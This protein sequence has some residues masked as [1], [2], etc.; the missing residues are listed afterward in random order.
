LTPIINEVIENEVIDKPKEPEIDYS[1]D[2]GKLLSKFTPF[3]TLKEKVYD[4]YYKIFDI[5]DEYPKKYFTYQEKNLE[6]Y[7]F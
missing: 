5:T 6:I 7:F 4:E 2:I 3:Y 1:K